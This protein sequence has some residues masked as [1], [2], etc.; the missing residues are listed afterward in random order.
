MKKKLLKFLCTSLFAL[1]CLSVNATVYN[2]NC[3]DS[4]GD[5]PTSAVTWSYDTSTG[6]LTLTGTGAIKT[7]ST[8]NPTSYP[9]NNATAVASFN[10][11][12][13]EYD[14]FWTGITSLVIGEG[15]TNVPDWAFAMQMNLTTV[16]LPSTL[17]SIGASS[18]EECAFTTISLPT[19]LETIGDYAFMSS[20]LTA[21][22][23]PNSVTAI[24][25]YAFAYS[26]DIAEA[27][28]PT[29]AT[30]STIE[31]GV[32]DGCTALTSITIP[33]NITEIGDMAL[34]MTGLTSVIIPS[35][36]TTIGEMALEGCDA[37]TEVVISSGVTT[38]GATAF[39]GC[40][41]L[42]TITIPSTVTTI[43]SGAFNGC[44]EVTDVYCYADP[45]NLTWT[46]D[47]WF[48]D[49]KDEQATKFHVVDASA[50]PHTTTDDAFYYLYQRVDFEEDLADIKVTPV[51]GEHWTT[52]YDANTNYEVDENTAIMIIWKVA[53][54]KIST[55]YTNQGT[56]GD[57]IIPAGH[58]VI[59]RSTSVPVL[60]ATETG[61]TN[62]AYDEDNLLLGSDGTVASD[63]EHFYA[64]ANGEAGLGFY[65]VANGTVIPE[66]KAYLYTG[67]AGSNFYS[68]DPDDNTTAIKNMKI[69]KDSNVYYDLSGRR[70]LYPKKGLYIMNGKKVIIK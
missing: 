27:S 11:K 32:F 24:G 4:E 34:E 44:T 26:E 3:G 47:E 21:I 13:G 52:F 10:P 48:S 39:D 30:Y 18:L 25:T 35:T 45:N 16:T 14:Q 37:L 59:L 53:D 60:T 68:I 70:V 46:M 19:G 61:S 5:E 36:V 2:G 31:E 33:N 55:A 8:E 7:Y 64:L 63:G 17:T 51:G 6:T 41:A 43:G 58:A 9:W 42:T 40:T 22:S 69:G 56:E 15:I 12:G 57:N 29:N 28:L 65:K 50:W 23:I 20:K 66:G 62:A 1:V 54:G 49:F 67:G 38:I